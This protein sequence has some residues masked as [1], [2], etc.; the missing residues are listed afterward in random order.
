[1]LG[2]PRNPRLMVCYL[3]VFSKPI[4][5]VRFCGACHSG[6]DPPGA[7]GEIGD[8]SLQFADVSVEGA[9]AFDPP[10]EDQ[11]PSVDGSATAHSR[12]AR[13]RLRPALH[14]ATRNARPKFNI[15]A[16]HRS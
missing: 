5:V 12:A 16:R 2:H 8:H 11:E 13:W 6:A 4:L 15:H 3:Y 7:P 9:E 14:D 10:A 1:M